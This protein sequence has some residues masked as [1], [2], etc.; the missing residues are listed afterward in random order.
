M[1]GKLMR[2][3]FPLRQ[4]TQIWTEII[5]FLVRA[6]NIFFMALKMA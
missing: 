6:G 5:V 3:G 4:V 2:T 1:T